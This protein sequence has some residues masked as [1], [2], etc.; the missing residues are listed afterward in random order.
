MAR[1]KAATKR[2]ILP[3]PLF[4]SEVLAKF[5]NVLMYN[6]KKSIAEKVVYDA[7]QIVSERKS[8]SK[9]SIHDDEAARS[10]I[11]EIFEKSLS[12]IKPTV[13]VKSCRVGG[14]TYQVP[15]EVKATRG[16]ALAMRWIVAA[17]NARGEKGI[18]LRLAGEI[19]DILEG[20]GGS[21]KKRED[22]HKMAKANQAF[23][24]YRW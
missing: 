3:D 15:V 24:H 22:V 19:S 16:M 1:R 23:A 7:L 6:G 9:A 10:D 2:T 17:A 11:L 20:K 13:E 8:K 5:I 14:A 21:V 18:V 12:V 4:G